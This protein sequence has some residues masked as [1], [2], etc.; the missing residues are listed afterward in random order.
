M[1]DGIYDLYI[2][3]IECPGALQSWLSCNWFVPLRHLIL[4]CSSETPYIGL[5]F[6]FVPL[7]HLILV[8]V[9]S[10]SL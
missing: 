6:E 8:C 9:L 3:V 7:R 1:R 4:V 10:L 5:S 2:L